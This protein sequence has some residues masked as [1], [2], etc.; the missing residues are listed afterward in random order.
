MMVKRAHAQDTFA[1]SRFEIGDLKDHRKRFRDEDPAHDEEEA[2][3]DIYRRLRPG[4]PPTAANARALLSLARVA[5]PTM[6]PGSSI[7]AISSLGVYGVII[8]GWAS[9]SKYAFLGALRAASQMVSYEVALGL[10]VVAVVLRTH[11]LSTRAIVAGQAPTGLADV[12]SDGAGDGDFRGVEVEVEGDEEA[13][14]A[15]SG[16]SGGGMERGTA[17]VRAAGR[18]AQHRVA[19]TFKLAAA[20]F[21]EQGAVRTGGG[22]F[23]EIDGNLMALPDFVARLTG[24]ERALLEGD[25]ANGDKGD[26]VG[27]ADAGMDAFLG[28]EVDELGGASG[29]ANGGFD[30]GGGRAGDG[31]D[32]PIV[33]GVEGI[34]EE[35]RAVNIHG[36]DDGFDHLGPSALGEI[37]NAFDEGVGHVCLCLVRLIFMKAGRSGFLFQRYL[38]NVYPI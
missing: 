37:G 30:N 33:V 2:L 22:G 34:V 4:D 3:K 20:D 38:K 15:H 6:P 27:G 26:D 24:E 17:N 31:D 5:V 1:S 36:G 28:S 25:A 12:F 35:E 19:Q 14:R 11:S 8:A 21:F 32:G 13:A 10:T 16:G 9:N 29:G 23:V 18:F 7:V